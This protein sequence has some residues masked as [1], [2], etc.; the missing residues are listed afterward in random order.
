[1]CLLAADGIVFSGGTAVAAINMVLDAGIAA[2]Q[3]R[4]LIVCASMAGIQHVLQSCPGVHLYIGTADAELD[5]AGYI[6]PG[7]FLPLRVFSET[8][9]SAGLGDAGDRLFQT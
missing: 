7:M 5:K 9:V 3:I 1:M 6:R 2:S 8:H 4:L